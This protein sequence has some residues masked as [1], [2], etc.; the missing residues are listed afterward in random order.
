MP[1]SR[2]QQGRNMELFFLAFIPLFVAIDV[3]GVLP[4][5]VGLVE[6]IDERRRRLIIIE[7]KEP[8]RPRQTGAEAPQH[9]VRTPT[10]LGRSAAAD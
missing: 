2:V 5:F 3:L 10:R 7:A 1:G 9:K 4:L 8:P 6:S